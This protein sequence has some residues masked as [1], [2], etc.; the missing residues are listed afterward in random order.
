MYKQVERKNIFGGASY[1]RKKNKKQQ[2]KEEN[3][4][5]EKLLP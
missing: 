4:K 3:G 5:R 1:L 2:R